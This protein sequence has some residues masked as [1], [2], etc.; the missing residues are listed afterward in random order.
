M[1]FRFNPFSGNFVPFSNKATL[2]DAEIQRIFKRIVTSDRNALGNPNMFYDYVAC[3][4][5]EAPPQLVFDDEGCIVLNPGE[6]EVC[7]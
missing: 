4:W 5:V 6:P 3:K 2:D 1:S 7:E